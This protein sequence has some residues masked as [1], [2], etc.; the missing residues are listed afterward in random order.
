M[1]QW[2]WQ[3]LNI[4]T[5]E[6]SVGVAVMMHILFKVKLAHIVLA[7]GRHALCMSMQLFSTILSPADL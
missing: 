3:A 6:K 5:T 1:F 4:M 2:V 7:I